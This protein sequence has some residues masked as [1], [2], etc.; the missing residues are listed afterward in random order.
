VENSPIIREANVQR[1]FDHSLLWIL[2][3]LAGSGYGFIGYAFFSWAFSHDSKDGVMLLSF[4]VG[5]PFSGSASVAYLVSYT[6]NPTLWLAV[7]VAL[8]AAV[9]VLVLCMIAFREGSICVLLYV[10][11]MVVP[12]LFGAVLGFLI[13]ELHRSLSRHTMMSVVALL[14]F[15]LGGMEQSYT[16]P[17]A[18]HEMQR[19][20]F[21]AAAPDVVWNAI[22]HPA[23]IRPD[24]LKDGFAFRIG[25]PYPVGAEV[26]QPA[27]GGI[28]KSQWQ[29]GVSFDEEITAFES[30]RYIKWIYHFGKDSFPPGSLDDHL[31]AGGAYFDL[32]DTSYRLTPEG[33][34]TKLDIS[35]GYRVT[36]NFNWYAVPWAN[37]FVGDTA[38]TLLKFY[39]SRSEHPG[40]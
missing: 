23:N 14:P 15:A 27:V 21:I 1:L 34:G 38:T 33:D 37:F 20:A 32:K 22:L 28:R 40:S 5:I 10:G 16:A 30:D 19:S 3:L 39:K 4:L 9:I 13:A 8:L 31:K 25:A 7:K 6:K 35:V 36:T 2:I 26:I 12:C 11:M 24:E 17:D 18:V 29:R